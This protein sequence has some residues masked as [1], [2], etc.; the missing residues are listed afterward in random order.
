MFRGTRN[1]EIYIEIIVVYKCIS[2]QVCKHVLP[3]PIFD[4]GEEGEDEISSQ[5]VELFLYSSFLLLPFFFPLGYAGYHWSRRV[6][7]CAAIDG[8][9]KGE[10]KSGLASGY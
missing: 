4:S 5:S 9:K 2:I 8:Q 7:T 6:G 10:E 3:F 1:N